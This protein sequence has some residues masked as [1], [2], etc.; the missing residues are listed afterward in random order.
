VWIFSAFLFHGLFSEFGLVLKFLFGLD[1]VLRVNH[2]KKQKGNLIMGLFDTIHFSPPLQVPGWEAPVSET[3]TKLFG[4]RMAKYT[5]GSLL[6][7]TP[8]L[9]GVVEESLWCAPKEEGDSGQFHPVY[10]VIW[11]RILAGVYLD[12]AEAEARLRTVDRLDLIA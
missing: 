6:P 4:S 2:L 5:V 10:F 12:L 9:I 1:F 8:V 11:H 3:Q 7:E